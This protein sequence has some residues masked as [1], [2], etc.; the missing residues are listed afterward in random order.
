[1]RPTREC[2]SE[3][4]LSLAFDDASTNLAVLDQS[5]M[6][7]PAR[8]FYL[9]DDAKSK[10]IREKYLKHVARM[11][12]LSGESHGPGGQRRPEQ[13]SPWKPNWRKRRWI[14]WSGAIPRT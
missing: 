11:L 12:E 10:E 1:M 5:G 6:A 3:F 9:N 8:E 2:C 7:L 13:S 4:T 14:S